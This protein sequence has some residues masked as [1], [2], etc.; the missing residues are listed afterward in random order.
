MQRIIEN[1]LKILRISLN[2]LTDCCK[3][4]MCFI[5]RLRRK[6]NSEKFKLHLQ[7]RLRKIILIFRN[8]LLLTVTLATFN[9]VAFDHSCFD[10]ASGSRFYNLD[11]HF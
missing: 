9:F 8:C 10:L 4:T 1:L 5:G 2:H 11:L 3:K 6:T 7:I